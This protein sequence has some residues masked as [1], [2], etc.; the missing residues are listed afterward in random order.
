MSSVDCAIKESRDKVS[1]PRNEKKNRQVQRTQLVSTRSG[2]LN[3]NL[4][5]L[6]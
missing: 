1:C 2:T 4:L 6:Q 3:V 5:T